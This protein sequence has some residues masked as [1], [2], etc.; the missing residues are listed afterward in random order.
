MRY[1][2][3]KIIS[4]LTLNKLYSSDLLE[5]TIRNSGLFDEGF[6]K[7][8]YSPSVLFKSPIVHYIAIG[9]SKG[10]DP[11]PFFS[12][13]FYLSEHQDIKDSKL[14]PLYHYIIAGE[15]EGRKP[16]VYFSPTDYRILHADLHDYADNLL[17]HYMAH[18]FYEYR[19]TVGQNHS[20][21]VEQTYLDKSLALESNLYQNA[22]AEIQQFALTPKIS[23]L[24]PTYN[25]DTELLT[26]CINSVIVQSYPNWELMYCRRLLNR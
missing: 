4:K 17:H 5:E 2:L 10:F 12:T 25:T 18:G 13:S 6:Y 20:V 8:A 3:K 7:K 19:Q 24:M 26:A 9:A 23:I 11:S 15:A 14:N 16:S 1:L 21:A 22:Q